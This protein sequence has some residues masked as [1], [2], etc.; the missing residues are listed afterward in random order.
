M[1]FKT[2]GSQQKTLYNCVIV[3]TPLLIGG[4]TET[5]VAL[6]HYFWDGLG[7][8]E[9]RIAVIYSGIS[10]CAAFPFG[11]KYIKPIDMKNKYPQVYY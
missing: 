9:C 8:T 3:F 4:S 2:F 10:N 7:K 5:S 1:W 6:V 11:I